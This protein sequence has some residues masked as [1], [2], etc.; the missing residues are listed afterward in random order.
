[1]TESLAAKEATETKECRLTARRLAAKDAMEA[2][3]PKFQQKSADLQLNR[4]K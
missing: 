4:A 1:M 3:E 2:E